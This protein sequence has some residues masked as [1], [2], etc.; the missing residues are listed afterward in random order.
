LKQIV[1]S[2]RTGKLELL[3]VPAPSPGRGQLLVRSAYSVVSP[4]TE[5]MAMDFART[6]LLGKARKR[7]DLVRQV[8][9]KLRQEGPLQT[10]RAVT[11]RLDAP[12]PLG[13]SLAGVVEAVGEGVA[14]F[15]PGDRVACAGAG[16]ANHAEL[17]AVPENL[18]A[19]VPDGVSLERAAYATVGAIA[20]QGLRLARPTLGEVGAVIGLGL[21][22]QLA[23]QLLRANGVRVLG[24]DTDPVRVKQA[25]DQGA[26]WAFTPGE[27]P[28]AWKEQHTGGHGVDLALLAASTDSNAPIALAGELCR[29][30]GR[31]SI[32]GAVSMDLDRRTFYG[33]ELEVQVSMSYGPGRYDWRYEEAGLDYP[34]PYVRWTENRNLQAFL[35][36]AAAGSVDPSRL[37]TEA[38]DFSDAERAYEELARG[39][40][41]AL[42][43]VFRYAPDAA[44]QRSLPLPGAARAPREGELGLAFLGAGNYAKGMLL[45]ALE[46]CEHLRRAALVT[47]TG[48]SARRTAERFGFASCGTDPAAALDDPG[49]DLVFV[50]TR[51]D[52][53]ARYAVEAL[54]RGKAVWLEKPVGL[55]QEEVDEVVAAARETGGLLTVGYNRRF[56]PH[57]R[58]IRDAFAARRGPLAIDYRVAPGPPPAGTWHTDPQVGGG[59]V[60]GEVCHFVDLCTCLVGRPPSSVFARGSNDPER[61][62]SVV[63]LLGFPDGSAAAIHY[64]AR[65]SSELPKE[66]IEVSGDGLTASCDNFRST[67]VSGRRPFKT[68]NQ[69]KGQATAVAETV[70][71][72]RA[73]APSPIG[74]DEIAAVSSAT[75]AI[76]ESLRSGA[77][78]GLDGRGAT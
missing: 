64:L 5:K 14:G 71:A 63:A 47:A 16:Y 24:L 65:A 37:E 45:P 38:V 17:N 55:S 78:V 76:L 23:V 28:A 42:S 50:A 74:L 70:A 19:H 73:G 68:L 54:R 1:Q 25:L 35:A 61:D 49:V 2:P 46:R 34:L 51:H 48:A 41:R 60:V 66:R 21:I 22:G 58:A 8:A 33:K 53:H 26:E 9:R 12:Q 39:E 13:Y 31:V 72:V 75:F 18:V 3:E 59:R 6:S 44:A 30:K 43:L 29:L 7:P 20:L 62:D 4:G 15:A 77:A 27:L 40:R 10:Y 67:R 11:S 32:I 56:S 36:L 52:S 57:T 69:D